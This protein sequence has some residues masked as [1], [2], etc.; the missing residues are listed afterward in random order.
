MVVVVVVVQVPV[1]EQML[2]EGAIKTLP[3][4]G[5]DLDEYMADMLLSRKDEVRT[6]DGSY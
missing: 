2:V 4:G 6:N 3:V 1:Y 5:K